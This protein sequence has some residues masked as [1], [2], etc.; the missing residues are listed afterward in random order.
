MQIL[1]IGS[2]GFIGS[3]LVEYFSNRGHFVKCADII[4]NKLATNS[5][6]FIN[7]ENFNYEDLFLEKSYDVCINASGSASVPFSIENPSDDFRMN[8]S[9]VNSILHS[10]RQFS[11]TCK[12]INFSSA[13]VYG[14]PLSLPINEESILAPLSPYGFHKMISEQICYEFWKLY[15]IKT[16]S[17]RVFSAY[18]PQLKKQ[19]FWDIY[20]KSLKNKNI[21]LFGN[22]NETRDYI[23]I[24]DL[25]QAVECIINKAQLKGETINVASG[26]ETSIK[27]VTDIFADIFS[28]EIYFT[29]NGQVKKGDPLNWVADISKLKSIGFKPRYDITSGLHKHIEWLIKQ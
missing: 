25:C 19:L 14:N 11:P 4:K 21:E 9:S 6:S 28:K 22:G 26:I 3:N 10:I 17:L 7:P 24:D 18:G 29:F 5:F 1:I 12:F 23:F 20:Q 2:S 8:V 16:I 15:D 27:T 13:A